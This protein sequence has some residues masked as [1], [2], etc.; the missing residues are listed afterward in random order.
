[1]L[2][3]IISK[4]EKISEDFQRDGYYLA[5]GVF[6][7]QL[8]ELETSFDK[9]ITQLE[10]TTEKITAAWPCEALEKIHQKYPTEKPPVI[11]HT[12]NVQRYD[13]IWMKAFLDPAFLKYA[14]GILGEDVIL[15]HSKLFLKPAKYGSAFPVHQDYS[16]FSTI[17]DSMMAG[18]IHLS[19]GDNNM[20]GIRIF[21]GSHKL[22]RIIASSGMEL[23][24]KFQEEYP[25]E[26]SIS[27]QIEAGD[28]LFFHYLTLHASMP[29]FSN[30]PRKTVLVQMYNG[31]DRIEKDST[32]GDERV[33]L[34]GWNYHM[35]R[36]RA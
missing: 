31:H 21:P 34:N 5:K 14:T 19:D 28:V 9:I 4:S 1:M 3:T 6:R 16:Y 17:K 23:N 11:L 26:N 32:Q 13:S 2:S 8:P 10:S 36:H 7:N 15:H 25:I 35:T 30:T 29:N 33:V 27:L 18:V 24:R 12:H 22:G 20:G